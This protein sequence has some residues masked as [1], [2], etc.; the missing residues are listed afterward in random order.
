M[1]YGSHLCWGK[2]GLE[3][4]HVIKRAT[5]SDGRRWRR[6]GHVAIPLSGDSEYAVSRPCVLRDDGLYRMWYSRRTPDYCLG[7][8]ESR[9]GE[10]W[11]RADHVPVLTG[12][13]ADWETET[14]EYATV[15]DHG[16]F[17]YMLY[18]GNGYGRTGFGLAIL[19]GWNQS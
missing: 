9:D 3:M 12:A 19:D 15:F 7:Y 6:D 13:A 10:V 4:T 16:G 8:A 1:W 2:Q 18:N 14:V 11:E 5:S 17:R